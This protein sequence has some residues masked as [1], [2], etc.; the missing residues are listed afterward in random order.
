ML[1]KDPEKRPSAKE[2][3]NHI[4]LNHIDSI[5]KDPTLIEEISLIK[6][7]HRIRRF[8]VK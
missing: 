8:I 4:W 7:V 5:P 6:T 2:I 3:A 1:N